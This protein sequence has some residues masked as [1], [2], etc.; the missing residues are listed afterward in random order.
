MRWLLLWYATLGACSML[1]WVFPNKEMHSTVPAVG[2][3]ASQS[4]PPTP[5]HA[6]S[7]RGDVA[8]VR[9][10]LAQNPLTLQAVR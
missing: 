5:L 10:L 6:A 9:T 3:V 7:E 2:V 1:E 4:V 8:E